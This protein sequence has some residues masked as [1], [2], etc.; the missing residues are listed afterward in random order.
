[1]PGRLFH[2]QIRRINSSSAFAKNEIVW[3]VARDYFVEDSKAIWNAAREYY[4][5]LADPEKDE[6]EYI[7]ILQ[8]IDNNILPSLINESK[9]IHLWSYGQVQDWSV[10]GL[11]PEVIKYHYRWKYGAEIRPSLA[12]IS[13]INYTLDEFVNSDDPNHLG[14]DLKNQLVHDIITDS[15]VNYESGKLF[16]NVSL[17]KKYRK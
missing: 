1:V 16:D 7:S 4:K 17:I 8:Y 5:H 15:I 14:G 10:N 6:I 3:N 12:S 9:I 11:D 13:L 2:S